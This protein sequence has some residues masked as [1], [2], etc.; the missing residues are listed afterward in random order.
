MKLLLFITLLLCAVQASAKCT[1][2]V[3]KEGPALK[4]DDRPVLI[5]THASSSFDSNFAAK[6]GIDDAVQYAHE[7]NMQVVYVQDDPSDSNY[8][9][10]DCKPDSWVHSESGS[11]EFD[12]PSSEVYL[13]GGHL[14]LCLSNSLTTL[15]DRWNRQPP[16][17]RTVN[18][19]MDA[20][21]S[22]GKSVDESMPFF[23][24]VQKLMQIRAYGH[25]AGEHWGKA[26]LLEIMAAILKPEQQ[27][28]YA[29][30]VLPPWER[31]LPP[32]YRVELQ[33]DD[34]AP[35]VLRPGPRL[36]APVLKFRF[37]D[38]ANFLRHKLLYPPT[39]G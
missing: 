13:V 4:L 5:A 39:S 6:R 1:G 36:G 10:D 18:I 7:M 26:S 28:R 21:Y 22:N 2:Q 16:R 19:F 8:Y 9:F 34:A 3:L 11:L 27:L 20:V 15:V 35:Q 33:I 14:E 23:N 37:L 30:S 12:I 31:N 38:S 29:R 24:D 25:P 32:G 17:N